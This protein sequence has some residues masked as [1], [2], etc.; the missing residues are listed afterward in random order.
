MSAI[1]L[2]SS[3]VS[4]PRG[5]GSAPSEAGIS[6][7]YRLEVPGE[8]QQSQAPARLR[9]R[10]TKDLG[11]EAQQNPMASF[12]H[13]ID[14]VAR[15]GAGAGR[16]LRD[17]ATVGIGHGAMGRVAPLLPPEVH[18]AIAGILRPLRVSPILS[19]QPALIVLGLQGQLALH[20]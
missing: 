16:P 5:S 1:G 3:P 17:E 6:L 14:G 18:R 15:I 8:S 13:R 4:V 9:R 10:R 7:S 2:R 12:H 20:E 19:A 11:V